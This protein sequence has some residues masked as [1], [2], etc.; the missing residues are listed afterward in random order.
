MNRVAVLSDIHGNTPA[1]A[2]VLA[3]VDAEAVDLV[4]NLGDI[5]SGAVDPRGTLDLLAERPDIVTVRGNHER[6][7]LTLP[8]D[9]MGGADR[10]A[11]GVL[12]DADRTWLGSLPLTARPAPGV[13]AFHAVPDD[14]ATYLTQTVVEPTAE[15][16]KGVREATDGELVE[17]LGSAYGAYALYLCGHTHQARTR[18]LPDGSLLVNPGSVGWPAYADDAP[19]PHRV[20][21]GRPEA[22][23]A[24]LSRTDDGGW[25]AELLTVPYDHEEAAASAERLGRADLAHML[26]TGRLP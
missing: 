11:V 12:T 15:H 6:Q 21:A 19:H 18:P 10:I 1:L 23:F 20:E 26:R 24:V 4:L 14:D 5:V 9:E 17:R 8:Y 7:V 25:A 16:P 2:A 22:R 3:A 13:L